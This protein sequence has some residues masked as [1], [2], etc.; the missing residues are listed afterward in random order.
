MCDVFQIGSNSENTV[1][2][3]GAGDPCMSAMLPG[4][5]VAK[6]A[7]WYFNQN[8]RQ[9]LQCKIIHKTI[10]AE[11]IEIIFQLPIRVRQ[12]IRTIFCLKPVAC[13]HVQVI[14]FDRFN[15]FK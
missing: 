10:R 14:E 8:S 13:K 7:R 4:T 5:G 1:C 12:E 11:Y 2:C 3:P 6:L 15:C 9:C